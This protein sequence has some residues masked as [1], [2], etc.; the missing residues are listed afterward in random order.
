[1]Q[2][3]ALSLL[4]HRLHAG[5]LWSQA[6]FAFRQ[7]SHAASLE[8]ID[9]WWRRITERSGELGIFGVIFS[10]QITFYLQVVMDNE[11][12]DNTPTISIYQI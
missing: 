5:R 12:L 1:M 3:A 9:M 8:A 11:Y 7:A 6:T 4:T 10:P 2:I